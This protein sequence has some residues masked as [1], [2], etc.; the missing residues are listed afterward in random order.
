MPGPA[1]HHMIANELRRNI[2]L[3]HGLGSSA[4]YAQ[5]QSL[6]AL[7]GNLPYLF[8]GCQGPDFLFF[9]TK[10]WPAGPLGDGVKMYYEVYDAIDDI[11]KAVLKLVPAPVIAAIEAAGDAADAVVSSSSTLTELKQL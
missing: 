3:G 4:S 9:N 2:N 5:L 8:L 1:L 7:K 6:L 11:K 10:D